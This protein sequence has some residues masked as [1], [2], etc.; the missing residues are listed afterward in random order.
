MERACSASP[1]VKVGGH[2]GHTT[3]RA[4]LPRVLPARVAASVVDSSPPIRRTG[5]TRAP[6]AQTTCPS[7]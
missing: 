2:G 5:F 1:L 7:P 3:R 4:G 6:E